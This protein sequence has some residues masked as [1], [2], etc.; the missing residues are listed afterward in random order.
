MNIVSLNC[1]GIWVSLITDNYKQESTKTIRIPDTKTKKKTQM[2][3]HTQSAEDLSYTKLRG[4]YIYKAYRKLYAQSTMDPTYKKH[5]GSFLHKAQRTLHTQIQRILH[6]QT[7]RILHTQS[8]K[9]SAYTKRKGS[10]RHKEQ[11]T[12]PT[13]SVKDSADTHAGYL[14]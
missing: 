11:M 3:L 9:D 10:C 6:T 2:I 5:R 4:A 13:Q 14:G 7:Q 8:P 1:Q 12:L